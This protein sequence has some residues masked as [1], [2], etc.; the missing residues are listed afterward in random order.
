[1]VNSEHSGGKW[2]KTSVVKHRIE[3]F[4]L[5][6]QESFVDGHKLGDEGFYVKH[7]FLADLEPVLEESRHLCNF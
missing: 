4:G 1:M 3:A 7:S 6:L 2:Y 5:F